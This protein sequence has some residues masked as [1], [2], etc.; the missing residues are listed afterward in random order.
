VDVASVDGTILKGRVR[1]V[2]PTVQ[3]TNRTGLVYVDITGGNARPGMFAR[4][5]IAAG[6][7]PGLLVPIASVVTQDGYSY[8]FVLN[9]KNTVE[10]RRVQQAGV[11]GEKMEIAEGLRAGEVIAVKGAGF[12]KDGDTVTVANDAGA[13]PVVSATQQPGK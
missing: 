11:Q 6:K 12:L 10:R 2:A 7:G 8:V 1:T 9:G 3:T 5:E 13:Q 4:G